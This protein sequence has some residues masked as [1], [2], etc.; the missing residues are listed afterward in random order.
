MCVYPHKLY[1]IIVKCIASTYIVNAQINSIIFALK[2]I[3]IVNKL[4]K[5]LFYI[6][7]CLPFPI[8]ICFW[9]F[10]YP[11]LLFSLS[12]KNLLWHIF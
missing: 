8:F 11:L 10:E 3:Y 4:E 2:D 9:K 1:I 7:L 6:C 12:M 5:I